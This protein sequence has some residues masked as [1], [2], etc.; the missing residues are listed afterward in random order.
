MSGHCHLCPQR[1]LNPARSSLHEKLFS[2]IFEK[3]NSLLWT[4][5]YT[6][7][8]THTHSPFLWAGGGWAEVREGLSLAGSW[9]QVMRTTYPGQSLS[10]ASGV[11]L[12]LDWV[13]KEQCV[14]AAGHGVL[15]GKCS[16]SPTEEAPVSK[17]PS[18]VSPLTPPSYHPSFPPYMGQAPGA[19]LAFLSP[20]HSLPTDYTPRMPVPTGRLRG[21]QDQGRGD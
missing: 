14:Q 20:G 15:P 2:N 18:G 21:Q 3:V 10:Q 6:H 13:L 1:N 12:P 4:H 11:G 9:I 8:H 5:T 16:R 17:G 7:T 19:T